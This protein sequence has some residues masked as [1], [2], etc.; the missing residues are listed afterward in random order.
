MDLADLYEDWRTRFGDGWGLSWYLAAEIVKR[1]AGRIGLIAL[2]IE[3]DGLGWYGILLFLPDDKGVPRSW[4]RITAAGD[5]ERWEGG[6][7]HRLGLTDRAARG[8]APPSLLAGAIE[9]LLLEN[10]PVTRAPRAGAHAIGVEVCARLAL[11]VP[12]GSIVLRADEPP[13]PREPAPSIV[14]CRSSGPTLHLAGD[15]RLHGT[16]EVINLPARWRAGTDIAELTELV[17]K[18]MDFGREIS[19]SPSAYTM[20]EYRHRYAAWC[21]AR[22]AGRGLSGGTNA[23]FR[24]A[25]EASELPALLR[26]PADLWPS[27]AADFDRAH[28]TWCA[29][30]VSALHANGAE[31]AT[32]G[33]SAK[34]IAIYLK[35]LAVCGGRES[36]LL[37]RVA[38]PPIDRVLLRR[39]ARDERFPAEARAMW[40]DTNWTTLGVDS[41]DEVIA[42]LRRAGL[43]AGGFWRAEEWWSGDDDAA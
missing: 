31:S 28:R 39:L 42:S 19:A 32:F 30:A 10:A 1:Y 24:R 29:A 34:L 15:G 38:H 23:V 25:I 26:G 4:G 36:T 6:E 22:A 35:T 37:A 16:A 21:A 20:T 27:S 5:A 8:E 11:R 33:R 3:H 17:A 41:Y 12:T 14:L 9:H 40:A 18:T 13:K 43:D 7:H 2:P